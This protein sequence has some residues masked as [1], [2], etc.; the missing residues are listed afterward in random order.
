MARGHLDGRQG[1]G[2]ARRQPRDARQYHVQ[3]DARHRGRKA[4]IRR[5]S[6]EDRRLPD[7][8]RRCDR[9]HSRSRQGRPEDRGQVAQPV[10]LARGS[11]RACGRDHRERRREPEKG[12]RLAAEGPRVD[13]GEARRGASRDARSARRSPGRPVA[14][15]RPVRAFRFQDLAKEVES[16]PQQPQQPSPPSTLQKRRYSAIL[17]EGQLRE[18]V[19]K[20]EAAPLV[21]FDTECVGLEP[22][23]A[24][25]VGMSFA[26]G[27]EAV[28]LP[29]A[30]EYPAAPQQI[31]FG[32]ALELLK[33]WLEGA[34]FPKVGQ[35]VKFDCHVLA[36]QGLRLAGCVHDT[37]LESYVLEVHQ[38][39]DLD[40]L[41]LRHCGW[42]TI[43][44]DDV[45]GK[46]AT[47][48]EFSAVEIGRATEYAA[49]DADCTLA[50]HEILHPRIEQDKK[51][52]FVYEEI[53]MRVLPVLFRMERNGV[54]L[55]AAKLEA[56]SHELGK[57]MLAIEQKA[58]EAAGQPFNLGSPKQIQE[59]R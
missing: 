1:P 33:P 13:H 23:T 14:P 4:Q 52:L 43:S 10:R 17:T 28:Y 7:A 8:G 36:N 19:N 30:H 56:Q 45:T 20:L 29:L 32:T 12:P 47:R 34:G 54:L 38:R 37:L 55:D 48:I 53:E 51:L 31:D 2:A 5:A 57:E 21:G 40:A 46:G 16:A 49:E 22:M 42:Q 41:A 44:Y 9:Q 6:R 25:L 18:L 3:R 35:N 15:A 39:H 26:F 50:L 27:N 24:R 59:I 58:Y 11:D